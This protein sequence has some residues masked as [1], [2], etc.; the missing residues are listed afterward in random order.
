MA[1]TTTENKV[2][3]SKNLNTPKDGFIQKKKNQK[4]K[5]TPTGKVPII[6]GSKASNNNNNMGKQK[7][8]KQKN[9]SPQQ[10]S[11]NKESKKEN[12]SKTKKELNK[13]GPKQS[14]ASSPDSDEDIN[15]GIVLKEQELMEET[16]DTESE[17]EYETDK[18]VTNILGTSLADDTEEDDEEFM[19]E[20]KKGKVNKGV[21]MFKGLNSSNK[22]ND[23]LKSSDRSSLESSA[24]D[25]SDEDDDDEESEEEEEEED[26]EVESA[27]GIKALLGNSIADDDDDDEDFVEPEGNEEDDDISDEDEEDEA[28][29]GNSTFENSYQDKSNKDSDSSFENM[30]NDNKTIFVGNLPK[31]VTNK[32]LQKLF[33]QFGKIDSIRIRGIVPKD[34]NMPKKVA[35]ITKNVHPKLK[36]V[37]AY[38]R[39]TTEESAAAAVALNG[40]LFEGNHLRVDLAS[41]S[42]KKY[43]GKK[44]VFLGN[45]AFK[46]DE[47]TIRKHFEKCGEI[48]SVRVIKDNKTGIGKGF[49]YVNFTTED[50]VALAFELDGTTILNRNVI[51]KPYVGEHK[52]KHRKR[53]HSSGSDKQESPRKQ[54]KQNSG[55]PSPTHENAKKGGK[56]HKDKKQASPQQTNT[57]QGQKADKNKKKKE[58][59]LEKKKKILAKKLTAT[60]KKPTN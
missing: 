15:E 60:P 38:I 48:E 47:N 46:I 10:F 51:V 34:V 44:S 7:S 49:G 42:E 28:G 52:T 6:N 25:D 53:S 30:K 19:V 45:L 26:E 54:V 32:D 4:F 11:K 21:K 35:K 33:K 55:K 41:K 1:K 50:A 36:S 20:D 56:A 9:S 37:Y 29:E 2:L 16:D 27:L 58:S 43:D 59:K 3:N 8:E 31:E 13:K 12:S 17:E 57:F 14:K 22:S 5:Q 24:M 23:S 18:S 39:F 40:T